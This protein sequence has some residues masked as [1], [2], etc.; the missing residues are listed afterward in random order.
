MKKK[1]N[2]NVSFLIGFTIGILESRIARLTG[3]I[4]ILEAKIGKGKK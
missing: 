4:E 1:V 3:R 2:R